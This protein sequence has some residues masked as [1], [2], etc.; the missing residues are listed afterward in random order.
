MSNRTLKGFFRVPDLEDNRAYHVAKFGELSTEARTYSR[1]LRDYAN[2]KTYPYPS[3]VCFSYKDEFGEQFNTNPSTT[4]QDYVLSIGQ[5]IVERHMAGQIP[6]DANRDQFWSQLTSEFTD[7]IWSGMGLIS[8]MPNTPNF[9]PEWIAFDLADGGYTVTTKIW[10]SDPTFQNEYDEYETI[11]IPP[12]D[13]IDLVQSDFTT[14][15]GIVRQRNN[16]E[17]INGLINE[18]KKNK[19][20]ANLLDP[21]TKTTTVALK[22]VDPTQVGVTMTHHFTLVTWGKR[23]LEYA[24][25]KAAIRDYLSDN[26]T[27]TNWSSIYPELY[28]ETDFAIIPSWDSMAVRPVAQDIGLFSSSVSTGKIQSNMQKFAPAGFANTDNYQT[29]IRNN[30][31]ATSLLYRGMIAATMGSPNNKDK[32]YLLTDIYPDYMHASTEQADFSR[33]MPETQAFCLKLNQAMSIAYSVNA[34]NAIPDGFVKQLYNNRLF[35]VFVADGYQWMVLS[36][37]SYLAGV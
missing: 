30:C 13:P 8:Q 34:N 11:V 10:L 5:W 9:M 21:E 2:N 32:N 33:M 3:L 17:T 15:S 14:V 31:A 28:S 18:A 29:F 6:T 12:A 24:N 35:I 22:W 20:N 26:S 27:L 23:G 4:W 19:V 37:M 25:Q 7:P 1:D 36:R 16:I